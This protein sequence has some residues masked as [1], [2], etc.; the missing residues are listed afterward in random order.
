MG[1][2]AT[3]INPMAIFQVLI[4]SEKHWKFFSQVSQILNTQQHF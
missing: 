4:N 3:Y 2:T 1:L